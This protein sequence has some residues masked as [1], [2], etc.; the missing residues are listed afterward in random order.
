MKGLLVKDFKLMLAQKN[1]YLILVLLAACAAY[2]SANVAMIFTFLCVV[3]PMFTLS[4]VSY[5]QF[6]NGFPF[7]FSLPITRKGYVLE[8][9]T[10]TLILEGISLLLAAVLSVGTG[11]M[12]DGGA[13]M[14]SALSELV[15]M[16]PLM[17]CLVLTIL[18]VIIPVHL[19]Y[20][21]EKGRVVLI[22]LVGGLVALAYLVSRLMQMAGG[23]PVAVTKL[24]QKLERM[25]MGPVILAALVAT[26]AV[27]A[28]SLAVSMRIMRKKEY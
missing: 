18:S 3:V 17:G 20:G 4:S 7:L 24:L 25:G 16:I 19:K 21:A 5:D 15:V 13:D 14:A 22:I 12:L 28:I 2:F 9:Y 10:F 8:K 1:Y 11:A 6:D 27:V 23:E 26:G